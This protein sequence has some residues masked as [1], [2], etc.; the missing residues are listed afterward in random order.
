MK[1]ITSKT[2]VRVCYHKL[3]DYLKISYWLPKDK[4]IAM[5]YMYDNFNLTCTSRRRI[6]V[7]FFKINDKAKYAL[8]LL[9]HSD[10]LKN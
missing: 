7:Y 6:N 9:K 5:S 10:L 2:R 8:F 3:C 4:L 1:K